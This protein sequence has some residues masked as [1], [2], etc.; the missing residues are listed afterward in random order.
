MSRAFFNIFLLI[1]YLKKLRTA[2]EEGV[3]KKYLYRTPQAQFPS[4]PLTT[5]ETSSANKIVITFVS[6]GGFKTRVVTLHEKKE[7]SIEI[8]IVC[9]CHSIVFFSKLKALNIFL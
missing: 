3:T 7:V 2:G 9:Q 5:V 4:T 1:D 8:Q 6:L